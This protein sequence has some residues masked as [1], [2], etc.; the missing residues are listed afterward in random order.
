GYRD[1]SSVLTHESG[2]MLGLLHP[3]EFDGRDGAPDCVTAG[4]PAST[5]MYPVY[6]PAQGALSPDDSAGVCFLYPRAPCDDSSCPD[7]T[8]CVD[9]A[10]AAVCEGQVCAPGQECTPSGCGL[11]VAPGSVAVTACTLDTDCG[12]GSSCREGFCRKAYALL[13]DPCRA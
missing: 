11:S 2:H 5:T 12:V 13:G 10:C 8:S 4:I 3:C 1:V 9:G 6:D 7:G